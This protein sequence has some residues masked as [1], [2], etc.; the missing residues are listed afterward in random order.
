MTRGNP[1]YYLANE[2]GDVFSS[3]LADLACKCNEQ[4]GGDAVNRISDMFDIILIDEAQDLSSYDY[5][6]ICS[7]MHTPASVIVVSDRGRGLTPLRKRGRIRKRRSS[8]MLDVA[9]CVR[10]TPIAF[11]SA[12]AADQMLSHLPTPY[13]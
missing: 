8:I 3:R 11:L 9:N 2:R 4:V 10:S 5:D 12:T 13:F 7:L 1:A 6:Y